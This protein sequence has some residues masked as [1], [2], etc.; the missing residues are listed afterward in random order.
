M[1]AQPDP[2]GTGCPRD[3][4]SPAVSSG[5]APDA[6]DSACRCP[7][8]GPPTVPRPNAPLRTSRRPRHSHHRL[9]PLRRCAGP[10]PTPPRG[11]PASIPCRQGRENAGQVLPS[12]SRVARPGVPGRVLPTLLGS[13]QWPSPCLLP[14][15][16]PTQGPFP[17]RALPR[18]LS[19]AGPSATLPAQACPSRGPGCRVHGTDRASRVATPPILHTCRRHYPGENQ[20]VLVSLASRPAGGLP[21]S[22]GG[23]AFAMTVSGPAR[24]SLAFR[25]AWSLSRLPT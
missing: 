14:V 10:A 24:R 22:C 16:F 19:T 5:S 9:P 8:S 12:L 17:R 15:P 1:S 3:G 23:S 6:P 25:P 4:T 20:P 11:N 21:L 13:H 7:P 2:S 18:V